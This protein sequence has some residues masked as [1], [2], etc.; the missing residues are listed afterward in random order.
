MT[1]KNTKTNESF[2]GDLYMSKF[3]VN[4]NIPIIRNIVYKRIND[5]LKDI[6]ETTPEMSDFFKDKIDINMKNTI[7]KIL[8]DYKTQ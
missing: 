2:L 1:T 8:N 5:I 3:A 7:N 6:K 4:N